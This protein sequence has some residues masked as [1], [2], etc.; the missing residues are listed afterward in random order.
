VFV[1]R[2]KNCINNEAPPSHLKWCKP[3]DPLVG[4]THPM[5]FCSLIIVQNHHIDPKDDHLG[6]LNLEPPQ[7]KLLEESP[8]KIDPGPPEALEESLDAMRGNHR[9]LATL[10]GFAVSSIFFQMIE[11]DQVP[12][13]PIDKK[14]KHLLEDL[15][16]RLTFS[17]PSYGTEEMLKNCW[18]LDPFQ[19][20]YKKTQPTSAAQSVIFRLGFINIAIGTSM[21]SATMFHTDLPP[22]GLTL[23]NPS[24]PTFS[25]QHQKVIPLG[26]F[27]FA[28]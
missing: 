12:T 24:C 9:F 15:R 4:W 7:E 3:F 22:I 11:I 8:E 20:S 21:T 16:D 27:S 13:R 28:L 25:P 10:H 5:S 1:T 17:I 14:A 2:A 26:G 18:K 6:L 23:W 19:I